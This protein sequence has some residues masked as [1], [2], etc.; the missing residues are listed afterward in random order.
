MDKLKVI[1]VNSKLICVSGIGKMYFENGLPVSI[2]VQT[3]QKNGI[4][5]NLLNIADEFAKQ[6][7]KKRS[8]LN[9]LSDE[10]NI[11]EKEKESVSIFL[12]SSY[13]E[14]RELIFQSLTKIKSSEAKNNTDF[15]KAFKF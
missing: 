11:S 7:W 8:I 13:E 15:M 2:S 6:G 5:Y 14:Q 12:N 10:L 9:L 3:L 4:I 1:E